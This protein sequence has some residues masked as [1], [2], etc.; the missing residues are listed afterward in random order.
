[1]I[2]KNETYDFVVTGS[3]RVEIE[4]AIEAEIKSFWGDVSAAL[5]VKVVVAQGIYGDASV[6][7][8][9]EAEVSSWRSG[10]GFT[11]SLEWAK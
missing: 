7:R 4:Q 11:D 8:I 9:L 3:T 2:L 1:M 10:T 6:T 5:E